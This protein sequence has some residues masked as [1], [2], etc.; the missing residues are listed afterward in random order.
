MA[1]MAVALYL[2]RDAFRG[3]FEQD[4][5]S[6]LWYSRFQTIHDWLRCFFCFNGAGTY[7]PLSQETFFWL[8]QKVFGLQPLGFHLVSAACHLA[9]SVLVYRLLR[10][11][12][13]PLQSLVSTLFFVVHNAHFSS[14]FWISA[15]PE[16]LALTFY[17]AAL[18]SFIHYDREDDRRSY[19]LSL[20]FMGLALLS[21]ES[22]LSLPFVLAA[23]CLIFRSKRLQQTLPHFLLSGVYLL[24][25][26]TSSSVKAAPYS[27]TFGRDALQNLYSYLTW[28]SGLSGVLLRFKLKWNPEEA[29]PWV[30][31]IVALILIGLLSLSRNRRAAFFA[32]TWYFLALQ[33][34][35][36]FSGHI[37]SYYLGPALPAISLLLAGSLPSLRSPFDWRRWAPVLLL[38]YLSIGTSLASLRR[39]GKIWN[40]R[41]FIARDI[42]AQMA[43]VAKEV[44]PRRK[45]FILGL[46]EREF[47]PMQG[48]L[49]LRVFGFQPDSFVLVGV[50]EDTTRAFEKAITDHREN[51]FS[52]FF[53][54]K[55]GF[56]NVTDP[57]HRDPERFL[58][59]IRPAKSF[60]GRMEH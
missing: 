6:W 30:A 60:N 44:P 40:D 10:M 29:Y 8:G 49:A 33:P 3:F 51:E 12:C 57:F 18:I 27:L 47:G 13:P 1:V 23:Y 28:S 42:I 9:A 20:A 52:C 7:R 59:P 22:I 48:D 53:Y 5:F 21:K 14:L 50:N 45:T 56:T 11:F 54:D 26:V 19:F 37:Y 55:G 34:V 2:Y 32:V 17:L 4:D 43:G 15:L 39:E 35:L 46:G 24:L 41:S 58:S 16:P 36:Y 38:L 31:L 25:R